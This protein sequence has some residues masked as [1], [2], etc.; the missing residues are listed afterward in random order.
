MSQDLKITLVKSHIGTPASQRAVLN[1]M[2]LNKL[3]KSV[4]LKD[5]PE[6]RGMIR[7]VS[8]MVNVTE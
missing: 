7:K 5:T 6:I 2:G 4:V 1:G 8:H 3:N